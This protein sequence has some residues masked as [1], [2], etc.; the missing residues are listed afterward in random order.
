MLIV[1]RCSRGSSR[2]NQT[3]IYHQLLLATT[4]SYSDSREYDVRDAFS[5]AM[6]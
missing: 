5:V 2:H 1:Y 4:T 3:T 6:L